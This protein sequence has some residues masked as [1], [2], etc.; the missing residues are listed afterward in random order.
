MTKKRFTGAVEFWKGLE[1][2]IRFAI[3]SILCGLIA[4]GIIAINEDWSLWVAKEADYNALEEFAYDIIENKNISLPISENLKNYDVSF[5]NDGT[6]DIDLYGNDV[7]Y[8]KITLSEDY[9]IQS[10]Q[11]H[12][13]TLWFV[14]MLIFL[15]VIIGIII[16]TILHL[17]YFIF[18]KIYMFISNKP[19]NSRE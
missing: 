3:I 8:L 2:S 13:R 18:K 5:N 15:L 6:I 10:F 7:E 4:F 11:R 1:T 12:S 17:I 19:E 9:Q 14:T 16:S